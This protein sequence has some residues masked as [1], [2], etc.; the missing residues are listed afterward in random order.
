MLNGRVR[1]LLLRALLFLY[2]FSIILANFEIPVSTRKA[3]K[4]VKKKKKKTEEKGKKRGDSNTN[5]LAI[6][7][8]HVTFVR[9]SPNFQENFTQFL[10]KFY[11]F[12]ENVTQI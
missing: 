2:Q 8:F 4:D 9:I 10:D 6:V 3:T 7:T 5:T 11:N 1:L 12:T